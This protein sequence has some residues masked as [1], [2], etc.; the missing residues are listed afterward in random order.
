MRWTTEEELR[1]SKPV[2]EWMD[3]HPNENIENAPEDVKQCL[4]RLKEIGEEKRKWQ[5]ENC[6]V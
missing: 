6:E 5:I 4:A 1:I 2:F 3:M